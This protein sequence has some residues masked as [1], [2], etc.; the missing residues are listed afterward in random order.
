MTPVAQ[1]LWRWRHDPTRCSRCGTIFSDSLLPQRHHLVPRSEKGEGIEGNLVLLCAN[2][3]SFLHR[4]KM[5]T[6]GG[7]K[8]SPNP[9]IRELV[10]PYEGWGGECPGCGATTQLLKVTDVA[11]FAKS[12]TIILSCARCGKTFVRSCR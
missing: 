6:A 10:A 2:C 1:E 4:R 3:H 8:N 12:I 9:V 7:Q 5:R 11:E